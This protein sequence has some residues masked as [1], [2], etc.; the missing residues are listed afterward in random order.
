MP[1][2][3]AAL[4]LLIQQQIEAK[5]PM[6][7]RRV[8]RE[9]FHA[10]VANAGDDPAALMRAVAMLRDG[11]TQLFPNFNR[12]FPLRFYALTDGL[13]ITAA[14]KRFPQLAGAKVLRIGNRS[15]E[16]ALRDVESM[17][18]SDNEFRAK[19]AVALLSLGQMGE[20]EAPLVA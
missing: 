14:D 10:A 8:R 5:H 11:H 13:F 2:L 15:A 16:E 18:S 1:L 6:P 12:W 9:Q 19:D 3:A 4:A 17:F 20:L 7:F